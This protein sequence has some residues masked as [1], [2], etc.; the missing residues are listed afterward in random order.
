MV[1]LLKGCADSPTA[2][3]VSSNCN[4]LDAADVTLGVVKDT[5]SGKTGCF[6]YWCERLGLISTDLQEECAATAEPPRTLAHRGTEDLDAACPTSER[7]ARLVGDDVAWEVGERIV[8]DVRQHANHDV[9][10]A[11]QR[12]REATK[13]W[14]RDDRDT[15]AHGTGACDRIDL[16]PDDGGSGA[17]TT[18]RCCDRTG[19]GAEVDGHAV[20][21]EALPRAHGE[22]PA[23]RTRDEHPGIDC[24]FEAAE[25]DA[26]REPGE[27][28][29][30]RTARDEGVETIEIV[31]RRRKE[32]D[33]F[34]VRGDAPRLFKG[35]NGSDVVVARRWHL[36][37]RSCR[38]RHRR[39]L[40]IASP[41]L[42]GYD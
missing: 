22:W 15:V 34:V 24:D 33:R 26:A 17:V 40:L 25:L 16:G 12:R 20:W 23:L 7:D 37:I 3:E 29:A 21:R 42:F 14:S 36:R 6:Q 11:A 18:Y 41:L 31:A 27:R 2:R 4:S 1:K 38:C 5:R 32:F 28:F 19:S 13:E 30:G 35:C 9:N 39:R 8:R 10:C